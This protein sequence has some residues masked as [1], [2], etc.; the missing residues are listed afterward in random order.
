MQGYL[1]ILKVFNLSVFIDAV[2]VR[3]FHAYVNAIL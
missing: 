1:S 2:S 3:L